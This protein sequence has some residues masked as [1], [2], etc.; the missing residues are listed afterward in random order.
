MGTK[1]PF[2]LSIGSEI[3]KKSNATYK[4]YWICFSNQ[5]FTLLKNNGIPENNILNLSWDIRNS[6]NKPIGDYKL[7]ELII[8]D[9]FMKYNYEESNKYLK[10]IQSVFF[11]FV[12]SNQIRYVFGEMTFAYE[13][14]MYRICEDKLKN[15]CT[16][17]HPQSIRIPNGRFTFLDTE[18]Q[19]SIYS[20]AEYFYSETDIAG[21]EIP[22]LPKVPQRVAEVAQDV[23]KTLTFRYRLGYFNRLFSNFLDFKQT[24]FAKTAGR[25]R[26][27]WLKEVVT[28]EKNKLYYTKFLKKSDHV[29]FEDKKFFYITLHMQPEASVDVVGRYYEDQLQFIYNIWRI[30]PPDY[31]IVIKEHSNA[32]GNRGKS[33]FKNCLSLKNVVIANEN[34]PSHDL[35][36]SS[37]AVFTNSGTSALEGALFGKDV[38]IFSN[39]FFEKLK[40][41]HKIN[42]EDLKFCKSYNDLLSKAKQRDTNKMTRE[43][44]SKYILRSS[45]KGVIDPPNNSHLLKS[46]NNIKDIANSFVDFLQTT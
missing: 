36:K 33:F 16:F 5:E 15:R 4:I 27:S 11:D 24:D 2:Y 17:L 7:N 34:I 32:I 8:G 41:C 44:Y 20:K 30:L 29:E 14:L 39:I 10:S 13:M 38:F 26:R 18:F 1:I 9:R 42:I 3:E 28:K 6:F 40:F 31:F 23:A 43:E 35:I 19:E 21:I 12:S 46:E 45:F 37:K 25:D 22:I